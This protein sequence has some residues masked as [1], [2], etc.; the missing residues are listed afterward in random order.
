M[1]YY[2]TGDLQKDR[3]VAFTGA[4]DC[5]DH[6]EVHLLGNDD[7]R[8]A[9]TLVE[10]TQALSGLGLH[11]YALDTSSFALDALEHPYV[12]TPE[13]ARH[14]IASIL[15]LRGSILCDLNKMTRP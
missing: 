12:V 13:D 9:T 11:K 10:L 6:L 14:R 2:P 7:F 4:I 8:I 5:L 3:M 1:P 15:S